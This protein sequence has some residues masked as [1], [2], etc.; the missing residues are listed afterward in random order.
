LAIFAGKRLGTNITNNTATNASS[1]NTNSNDNDARR[2]QRCDAWVKGWH[3]G[4]RDTGSAFGG[5]IAR[6]GR[7]ERWWVPAL[8]LVLGPALASRR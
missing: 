8:V 3:F 7:R 5:G 6:C 4:A 1:A 2:R